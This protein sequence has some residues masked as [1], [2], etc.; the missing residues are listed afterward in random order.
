MNNRKILEIVSAYLQ[1]YADAPHGKYPEPSSETVEILRKNPN[2]SFDVI[3]NGIFQK[4]QNLD[5][6]DLDDPLCRLLSTFAD[7]VP[8]LLTPKMTD[9]FW[10]SRYLYISSAAVSKSPIFIPTII[11][12]L[13]DRSIYIKTLVLQLINQWSHL[14]VPEAMPLL[15]KLSKMKSF[16]NSDRDRELLVQA[17]K[18]VLSKL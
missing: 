16:Q 11:S 3:V 17:K 14:Q 10:A 5:P 6:R 4:P 13:T 1:E 2:E 12:L 18:C 8:D 15:E 9:G 7:L